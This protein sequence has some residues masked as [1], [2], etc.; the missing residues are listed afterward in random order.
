MA[1]IYAVPGDKR[2]DKVRASLAITADPLPLSSDRARVFRSRAE[3]GALAKH[4]PKDFPFDKQ[5][6]ILVE[7]PF[8]DASSCQNDV[9]Q[10]HPCCELVT[11]RHVGG[12]L[13]LVPP[14]CSARQVPIFLAAARSD[15]PVTLSQ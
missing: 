6:I 15:L 11:S 12:E 14:G 4:V 9:P 10:E 8:G 2:A 7:Q 1:Q 3:L 13:V 5:M